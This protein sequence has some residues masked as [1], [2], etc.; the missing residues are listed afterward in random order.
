[1]NLAVEAEKCEL[2]LK[3]Y[4]WIDGLQMQNGWLENSN[5]IR[6]SEQ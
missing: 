2:T 3:N 5:V 6:K 4:I 1:M